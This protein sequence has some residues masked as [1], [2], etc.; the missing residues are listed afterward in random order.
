MRPVPSDPNATPAPTREQAERAASAMLS[1]ANATEN[2]ATRLKVTRYASWRARFDGMRDSRASAGIA[3][4]RLFRGSENTVAVL[5]DVPSYRDALAWAEGGWRAAIPADGVQ[6]PP[7]VYFGID[8]GQD[9]ADGG[10]APGASHESLKLM[11]HFTVYDY[12]RWHELFLKMDSS[13]VGGG[14]TSPSIFRGAED[15]NDLLVLGDVADP[16]KF[17]AW[18]V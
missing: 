10:A 11:S 15:A 14:M 2:L 4:A 8:P 18:L 13:R 6:G 5:A 9:G 12:A 17:R 16:A 1:T 7:A 3:N